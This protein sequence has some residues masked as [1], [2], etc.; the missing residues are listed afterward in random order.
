M[1][2]WSWFFAGNSTLLL[3]AFCLVFHRESLFNHLWSINHSV[4][5]VCTLYNDWKAHKC[6]QLWTH[7]NMFVRLSLV[8]LFISWSV[9]VR[10]CVRDNTSERTDIT[11][12]KKRKWGSEFY[13]FKHF[14]CLTSEE[15]QS[16]IWP[17]SSSWFILVW[18]K[19]ENH[20]RG[21]AGAVT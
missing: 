20:S 2:A 13:W 14:I 5:H 12:K 7:K 9:Y 16:M 11:F 6:N 3:E 18:V 21:L 8:S 15:C 17:L 1:Y 19:V 10:V 4:D